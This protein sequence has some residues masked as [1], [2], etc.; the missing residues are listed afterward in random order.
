MIIYVNRN[1]YFIWDELIFR[2]KNCE[3]INKVQVIELG[4]WD[5]FTLAGYPIRIRIC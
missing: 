1:D 2:C 4:R 3:P 5:I